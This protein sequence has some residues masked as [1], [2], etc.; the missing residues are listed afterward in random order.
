MI[1]A[2]AAGVFGVVAIIGSFALVTGGL[3]TV[4]VGG[5]AGAGGYFSGNGRGCSGGIGDPDILTGGEAA[6]EGQDQLLDTN[7]S[8]K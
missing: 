1:G 5:V 7:Q 6:A 2:G 4:V 8:W 3:G